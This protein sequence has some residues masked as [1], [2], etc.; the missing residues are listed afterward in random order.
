MADIYNMDAIILFFRMLVSPIEKRDLSF[1]FHFRTGWHLSS[2]LHAN[3]SLT[4]KQ[5]EDRKGQKERITLAVC[6][7]GDGSDKLPLWI[8]RRFQ[9]PRC[10]KNLNKE[11]LGCRY[12]W[13]LKAWMIQFISS[14]GSNGLTSGW[15]RGKSC[16]YLTTVVL[17][18]MSTMFLSC[19]T[20]PSCTFCQTQ[21]QNSNLAI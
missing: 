11:N 1:A 9:F 3:K 4:M 21:R 15:R 14:S 18:F 17:T 8:I 2:L 20:Q 5:S 16:S 13:N 6:C 19:V 12:R 10:F 7:N